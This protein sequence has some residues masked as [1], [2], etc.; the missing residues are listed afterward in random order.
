MRGEKGLAVYSNPLLGEFYLVQTRIARFKVRV[1]DFY[2][3]VLMSQY[4]CPECGADL[5]MLEQSECS[6]SQGHSFDPTLTFQKST[7]CGARLV[8]RTYHYA[9]SQCKSVVPSRFIFDER[10]FDKAYFREMMLESRARAKKM[11]EEMIRILADSRS[12]ALPLLEE[13]CLETIP[14]LVEDL[15]D[16]VPREQSDFDEFNL[17]VN[18]GPGV[19]EYRSH[20]L[21]V[22]GWE[23]R[24]FSAIAPLIG[25]TRQDRV[26]RFV[27]LVF[28]Q[29][30][31]EIELTQ[32]ESDLLVEKMCDEAHLE[33]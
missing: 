17:V 2:F 8:R 18:M 33:G 16:F 28:M 5:A 14:G 21:A 15:N 27:T 13:P 24:F 19:N 22:L 4:A 31:G 3:E 23:G 10:I 9:C 6:C 26:W 29:H 1:R 32:F 12:G 7:C 30:D 25:D 11:K 20:I